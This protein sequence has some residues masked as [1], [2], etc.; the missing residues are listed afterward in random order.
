MPGIPLGSLELGSTILGLE[1]LVAGASWSGKETNHLFMNDE[2]RRFD[3]VSGISGLDHV[4]DGRVFAT[5]DFDRDGDQDVA[6]LNTN[7]PRFLLF[8]NGISDGKPGGPRFVALRFEGGNRPRRLGGAGTRDRMDFHRGC[9]SVPGRAA[10]LQAAG[11]RFE[12]CHL[13]HAS[14]TQRPECRPV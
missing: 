14:L 7:E 1:A 12:P 8:R 5:L 10:A 11:R 3:E 13:H 6:V 2:G 9:S 4:A